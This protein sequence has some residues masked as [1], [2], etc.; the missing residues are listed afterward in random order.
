MRLPGIVAILLSLTVLFANVEVKFHGLKD[1]I[2]GALKG[3]ED[4]VYISTY[5][6][7]DPD[8]VRTL[9]SLFESGVD[10]RVIAE[11]PV[12]GDFPIRIDTN[13]DS[14][15]HAK[16][17]VVDGERS[18]FGSAN[19]TV[20]GLLKE[21]ND[22]LIFD[23]ETVARF[24]EELFLSVWNGEI[25]VEYFESEYGVF[26]VGPFH[27][28]ELEVERELLRSKNEV[29]M[30]VFAF[31]DMNVFASLKYLTSKGVRVR[32]ILDDWCI[33]NTSVI[34]YPTDQFELEIHPNL[35]HKFILIDGR[36]LIT[37]SANVSESGY[38]RNFEV[39]FIT[40]N[41]DIV[42]EYV[43]YFESIWR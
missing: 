3:A 29:K 15:F 7:D 13:D 34:S 22:V 32:M 19:F 23:D 27:D 35:H 30:A 28:L 31:S 16:F 33:N 43:E 42:K 6:L 38:H 2:L 40:R 41:R 25:P 18:I 8:V 11:R 37:G 24:F 26:Y 9:N 36:T 12:F 5:S 21:E 39:V 1:V 20:G 17:M 14:T 10:V 4:F